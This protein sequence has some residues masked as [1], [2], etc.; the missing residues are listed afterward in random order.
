MVNVLTINTTM[1][2]FFITWRCG[3]ECK[4]YTLFW[5]FLHMG[6]SIS[7]MH[8]PLTL[9]LK[10][11]WGNSKLTPFGLLLPNGNWFLFIGILLDDHRD[12]RLTNFHHIKS[13]I[14]LF[15]DV[16]CFFQC[17]MTF[18][19][20]D[21]LRFYHSICTFL[22]CLD[23]YN[24]T[25]YHYVKTSSLSLANHANIVYMVH[26]YHPFPFW[27]LRFSTFNLY[28]CSH[29]LI[30]KAW[31]IDPMGHMVVDHQWL[32]WHPMLLRKFVT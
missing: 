10:K 21:E 26:E 32:S 20:N 23:M 13:L 19:I 22:S 7:P 17:D 8:N 15:H 29:T 2:I 9:F 27:N 14:N 6:I 31:N 5:A 3:F 1:F 25:N 18:M 28:E 30:P 11:G 12:G 4:C 24:Y 16:K